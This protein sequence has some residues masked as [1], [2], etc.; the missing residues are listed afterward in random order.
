MFIAAALL[1][2]AV[3]LSIHANGAL[4]VSWLI[5]SSQLD[6]R[7]SLLA[8][9]LAPQLTQV[10]T[11]KLGSQ[12]LLKLINQDVDE[13][14]RTILL[15]ALENH[16]TMHEILSDQA[17]GLGFAIK[18]ISG[19]HLSADEKTKLRELAHPILTQLQGTGFKKALL[20]FVPNGEVEEQVT[21]TA[22]V[23]DNI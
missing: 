4:L 16:D 11:H 15:N 12:I 6:N 18:V 1:Q 5:E 20:E 17:R 3:S 2:N 10:A 21:T 8:S 14:A 23:N 9:R 22:V 13:Q 19:D 7:Y